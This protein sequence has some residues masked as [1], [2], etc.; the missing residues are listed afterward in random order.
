MGQALCVTGDRPFPNCPICVKLRLSAQPAI[1]FS[2]SCKENS[3]SPKKILLLSSFWKLEFLELGNGL[4]ARPHPRDIHFS[5]VYCNSLGSLFI[6]FYSNTNPFLLFSDIDECSIA[7]FKCRIHTEC[8]NTIGSYTCKC[9]QGF[10]SN[11][12]HCL[13]K[14][15]QVCTCSS[16]LLIW[17][18]RVQWFWI[19]QV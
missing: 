7:A 16:Q 19:L 15:F 5:T 2:F 13:G 4:L 12:P 6:Y 14:N 17:M 1:D 8:V 10:Y 18:R 11:G 9:K 3:F